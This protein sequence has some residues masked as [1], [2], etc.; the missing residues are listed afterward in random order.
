MKTFK[1]KGPRNDLVTFGSLRNYLTWFLMTS[2]AKDG[3]M[4][5]LCHMTMR[6]TIKTW[7]KA[8]RCMGGRGITSCGQI[9]SRGNEEEPLEEQ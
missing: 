2:P 1:G 6:M 3:F 9:P 5:L 4:G 8:R 7:R